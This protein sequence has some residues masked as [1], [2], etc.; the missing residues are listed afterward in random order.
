M[1]RPLRL[2]VPAVVALLLLLAAYLM[3]WDARALLWLQEVQT[4]PAQQ[5]AQVWL[6]GY[7]AV[8]AREVP[9]FEKEEFSG[10]GYNPAT[11]TLF[12]VSGKRPQLVELSL[13]GKVLRSIPIKGATNLEGVALLED[14]HVAVL[15]ERQRSLTIFR[16]DADTRELDRA[17]AVQR[18]ELGT[19]GGPN[20][21]FEGLAWDKRN[22]RLLLANEKNPLR[23][24]SLACDGRQ[25][26][27]PL[28]AL[29]DLDDY[30]TDVAGLSVDPRN[31]QLLA[32]SQESHLL[33]GL[34]P[35]LQAQSFLALLPGLNGLTRRV[36]QAEGLA[37]DNAGNLYVVSE[38]NLFFAFQREVSAP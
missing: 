18:I 21:G 24:F 10:L 9:G 36:P 6:P 2:L 7:R 8:L 33:L 38:R 4:T 14:G 35:Q 19:L 17:Q 22:Q 1:S 20:K 34:D 13:A 23:L 16:L 28:Q 29:G 37:L 15:D 32:L 12:A 30:I 5:A 31:G 27:G 11:D 26:R 3:R 25:V